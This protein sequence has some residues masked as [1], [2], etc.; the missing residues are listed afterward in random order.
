MASQKDFAADRPGL[1]GRKTQVFRSALTR[2]IAIACKAD[3]E[4]PFATGGTVR[5]REC[6]P[7]IP[8]SYVI[9]I[10]CN[11]DIVPA[12]KRA[13]EFFADYRGQLRTPAVVPH[14]NGSFEN[15]KGVYS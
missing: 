4:A 12:L 2:L 5:R 6:P 11:S 13:R 9:S 14:R 15:P 8:I 1:L 7:I 10:S 3:P